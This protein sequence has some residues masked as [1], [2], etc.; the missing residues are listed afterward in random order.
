MVLSMNKTVNFFVSKPYG[1][2]K[3]VKLKPDWT[4]VKAVKIDFIHDYCN[5]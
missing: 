3:L 1:R 4:I 5:K 2:D